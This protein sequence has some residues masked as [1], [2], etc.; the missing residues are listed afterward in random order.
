MSCCQFSHKLWTQKTFNRNWGQ[1]LINRFPIP[2]FSQEKSNNKTLIFFCIPVDIFP[3]ILFQKHMVEQLSSFF[4]TYLPWKWTEHQHKAMADSWGVKPSSF[5]HHSPT[6]TPWC[7]QRKPPPQAALSL[8][9]SF[10]VPGKGGADGGGL[11]AGTM[12]MKLWK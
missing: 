3:L 1:T 6:C 2:C 10:R 11:P 12:E 9:K 5:I 4:W 7:L 8:G